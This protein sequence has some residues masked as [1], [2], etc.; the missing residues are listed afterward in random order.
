MNPLSPT[1]LVF[2]FDGLIL[3]TEHVVYQ[4]WRRRIEFHGGTIPLEKWALIVGTAD[5]HFDPIAEIERL[6]GHAVD[7]NAIR[8]EAHAEIRT[9]LRESEPMP[10]VEAAIARAREL[11]LP[12][13]V[14]SSSDRP[15]V[16]GHLE[17]L[18]LVQHFAAICTREEVARTKPDP[19]LYRLALEKLGVMRGIALE[20]SA[21][22]IAAARGAGLFS[23]AVPNRITRVSDFSH[24]DLMLG[25]L[26]ELD[27]DTLLSHSSNS[28]RTP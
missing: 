28:G 11:G 3:D 26:E 16:A 8:A 2:D 9:A 4:A 23:V 27:L 17:R 10:G 20:D 21:N 1:A 14:A 25:S 13:A 12:L 18:G 24:A 7:G 15:W 22:G 5:S 19:A 6:V